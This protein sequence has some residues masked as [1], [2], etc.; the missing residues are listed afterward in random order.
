MFLESSGWHYSKLLDKNFITGDVFSSSEPTV[1][2]LS[3]RLNY[4]HHGRA[5][6]A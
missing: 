4:H 1:G 3:P 5:I 6:H 2:T